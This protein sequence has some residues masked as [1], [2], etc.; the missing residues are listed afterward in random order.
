MWVVIS[1]APLSG[2]LVAEVI[3][4]MDTGVK[5]MWNSQKGFYEV[6]GNIYENPELVESKQ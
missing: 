4:N 2:G 6:I 5:V 3:A 1:Y